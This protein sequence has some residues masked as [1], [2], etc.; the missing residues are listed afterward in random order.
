MCITIHSAGQNTFDVRTA[1][2]TSIHSI[3]AIKFQDQEDLLVDGKRYASAKSLASRYNVT[4]DYLTRMARTNRVEAIIFARTW[5]L[6]VES[7]GH[8]LKANNLA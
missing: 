2:D 4:G 8:F 3:A 7:V 6:S 5:Y 1:I